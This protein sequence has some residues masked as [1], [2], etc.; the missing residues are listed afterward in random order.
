MLAF[1]RL[2]PIVTAVSVFIGGVSYA[3]DEQDA[4][5]VL[6]QL[7][8]PF[9]GRALMEQTP[10]PTQSVT[11][12]EQRR[13]TGPPPRQRNPELSSD[14]L[15]VVGIH[16]DGR[17]LTRAIVKDPR[18]VRGETASPSGELTSKRMYQQVVEFSVVILD[19]PK[20]STI[21]IYHPRWTGS[22][23]ILDL[24]GEVELP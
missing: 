15:V 3:A 12:I 11:V 9:V 17:E 19:D 18:L 13:A 22:K 21:K 6:L 16:R 2:V 4:R 10:P 5:Q 8:T 14:K 24:I 1:C 23:F 20:I 7:A